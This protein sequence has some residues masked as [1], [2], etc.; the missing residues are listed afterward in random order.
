MKIAYRYLLLVVVIFFVSCEKDKDPDKAENQHL[1]SVTEVGTQEASVVKLLLQ[2]YLGSAG[3]AILPALTHNV[4]YYKVVYKTKTVDGQEITASGALFIPQNPKDDVALVGYSHGT[5]FDEQDA[6]SYFRLASES[7]IG[8]VVGSLG[9][10]VAMPDYVGYGDSKNVSHPYE[11]AEGTAKPGVDFL[12]AVKE[13]LQ[14][15]NNKW[16]GNLLMAGYSQGGY[17]TLATHKLL[18]EQFSSEF[19]HKVSVCGA[20]AYSKSK[21]LDMLVTENSAGDL[22]HNRS[23]VWV[24]QTYNKLHNLNKPLD[25]FFK[26]EIVTE[27][28]QKGHMITKTGSFNTLLNTTFINSYKA[29]TEKE[30]V[31]IFKKNDLTNF[32]TN[33]PVV[34]VHGSNDTYVPYVNSELANIGLKAAG[35]PSVTLKTVV[36]GDHGSSTSQF[37]LLAYDEF[38]KYKD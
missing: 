19:K 38:Q 29:G 32:R 24:M 10:I 9:Y 35:S 2:A 1:V 17:A 30:I 16:N 27:I 5:I 37:L 22:S 8:M 25:Y 4:K 20:G 14:E 3:N 34:L 6:P 28:S 33:V 23:Y 7:S 18:E 15:N 36:G 21:M 12:L 26:P 11:H 13:Y 31:D